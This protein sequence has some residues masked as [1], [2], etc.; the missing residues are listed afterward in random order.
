MIGGVDAEPDLPDEFLQ[1][2]IRDLRAVRLTPDDSRCLADRLDDP[3]VRLALARGGKSRAKR[4]ARELL[5]RSLALVDAMTS[6]PDLPPRDR[7]ASL[8]REIKR[9]QTRWLTDQHR[10]EMPAG[11]EGTVRGHL[12]TAFVANRRL[13]PNGEA[14]HRGFPC[15]DSFLSKILSA[16]ANKQTP[17]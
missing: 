4:E 2:V 8:R 5:Y 3:A 9:Y 14:P 15:S 7:F 16:C 1:R 12:F 11:Y 13:H 10:A 6:R 17:T